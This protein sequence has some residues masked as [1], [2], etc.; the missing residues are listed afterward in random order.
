VEETKVARSTPRTLA[1]GFAF[2]E[3][4]RWRDGRLYASDFYMRQVVAITPAGEVSVVCEMPDQPSG[5][6][7]NPAG[8][9]M[10][11]SM[12]DRRILRLGPD[13]LTEFADL[14]DLAPS[15]CNDMLVDADGAA[16][17]GNFGWLP[18]PDS[19]IVATGLIL[20]EPGK[21]PRIVADDVVF[22]N[23]MALT[24]QGTLLVSESFRSR[25]TEFDVLPDKSLANR[26]IWA[27]FRTR[28]AATIEEAIEIGDLLPDGVALDAEGCLWVAD[29]NGSGAHR[30]APGG[31]ILDSVSA[32]E[33]AVYTV[34]L[35]GA[36]GRTLF[37]C[38]APRLLTADLANM[39]SSLVMTVEVDIPAPPA[40]V[41]A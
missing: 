21:P 31:R 13:G 24:G 27:D 18:V 11:S 38:C 29:A 16:Y 12:I 30:V 6:G 5:L 17:V 35:G 32:G 28:R 26:R 4:A 34:A 40:K 15:W 14:S 1:D 20:A 2:L 41:S 37:L 25:I 33:L 8:E 10:I 23:G 3:G 19:R 39:R 9:L 7:F 36:D 22:P